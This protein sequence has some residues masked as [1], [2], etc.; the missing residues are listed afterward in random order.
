MLAG[1]ILYAGLDPDSGLRTWWQLRQELAA[2]RERI[3][4]REA[5]IARLAEAARDLHGDPFAMES[6]IRVDL[7]LA[8][9]GETIVLFAE[10]DP[11]SP[12]IP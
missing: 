5:E 4:A 7:G 6:A 11:S 12:R 10:S 3:A 2:S 8:R 1:A 9:P